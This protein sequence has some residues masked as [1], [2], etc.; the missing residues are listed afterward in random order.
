MSFHQPIEDHR[1]SSWIVKLSKEQDAD[2][3]RITRSMN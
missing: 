1:G 2:V 3:I